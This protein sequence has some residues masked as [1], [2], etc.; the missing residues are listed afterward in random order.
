MKK[1]DPEFKGRWVAALRSGNY[2]Q[3]QGRLRRADDTYCC[4]GVAC[5]VSGRGEWMLSEGA[6]EYVLSTFKRSFMAVPTVLAE[7]IGLEISLDAGDPQR[8]LWRLNDTEGRSFAE[9]ADWI[10]ENL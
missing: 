5:D 10:E 2:K 7:E 9:I 3:G 6:Y 4:L 8:V 1:I